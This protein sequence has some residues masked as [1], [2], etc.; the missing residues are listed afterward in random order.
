MKNMTLLS[1][2]LS[3]LSLLGLIFASSACSK[4]SS[5]NISQ[6]ISSE[7]SNWSNAFGIFSN[8]PQMDNKSVVLLQFKNPA[9]LSTMQIDMQGNRVIDQD[10]LAAIEGE[11]AD[12]I[13]NFKNISSDITVMYKYRM[14]LNAMAIVAPNSILDKLTS[15]G[16]VTYV[17]KDGVFAKPKMMEAEVGSSS[18]DLNSAN[19]AKFIGAYAVHKMTIKDRTGKTIPLDGTGMRVGIIDTGIDYTHA[20]LGGAGT[21][22]AFQAIDPSHPSTVFPT[23]KVIGG[24]D[25]VGTNYDSASLNSDKRVPTP[26][27]NPIDELGHGSHVAGTIAGVG[28][29]I[30]TYDG[31]APGAKLYAIKVFGS[32]GSSGDAVVIAG[33]EYAADPTGQADP[34]QSLDAVNLSLG[35]TFGS[36]HVLYQ[37]A[38]RNLTKAGTVVVAAAGNEGA[39]DYVVGA[40]SVSTDALSIAASIDNAPQ[41]WQFPAVKFNYTGGSLVTQ[42][43]AATI[44]TSLNQVGTLSGTLVMAGLGDSDF[45][46]DVKAKLKGQVAL[47]DR[48][49]VSFEDKIRR[50]QD[51]G[52]IGVVVANT[53]D[54]DPY[55]MGGAGTYSLPAVMVSQG[56]GDAVKEKMKSGA[57]TIQF[58]IPDKILKKELI[59][60]VA[61]FSSKG[62]RSFDSAIKPEISA[63]GLN[64]ISISMGSGNK[65]VAMSGTSMST[66]HM[67]GV[68]TV[69]KELHPDLSVAQLKSLVMST[70]ISLKDTKGQEYPVSFQGA[71][72]VRLDKAVL[73][74]AV[75]EP[76]ALSLGEQNLSSKKTVRATIIVKNISKTK[77]TFVPSFRARV[78]GIQMQPASSLVLAPGDSGQMVFNFTLDSST[79]GDPTEELDG[80]LTLKTGGPVD[81]SL[82]VLAVI[83]KIS[84]I[85]AQQLITHASADDAAGASVDLKVKNSG[86]NMGDVMLFNLLGLDTRKSNPKHAYDLDTSCNLQAAGYRIITKEISGQPRKMIQFAAKLFEPETTWNT[87]EISVLI[88]KDGKGVPSQE[89]A[90]IALSGVAGLSSSTAAGANQFSSV[91]FDAVRARDIRKQ[92]ELVSQTKSKISAL[93][94]YSPS[95][96]DENDMQ[97]INHTTI[98]IIEAPIDELTATDDGELS[99]R[100]ATISDNVSVGADD[101]LEQTASQWTR[102]SLQADSQAFSGMPETSTLLPGQS[103]TLALTK[104]FGTQDLLL[105][106]PQNA[107]VFSDLVEDGQGQVM[108]TEF[109]P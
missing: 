20:M 91:L 88:D 8:R 50:A 56:A 93:E 108:K 51:A 79:V 73:A 98:A 21:T 59:D 44:G 25:F 49:G 107:N 39:L 16:S 102:I 85:T 41:N 14:V 74:Q 12:A 84:A 54:G 45:A 57:V 105:L 94:D 66:P 29:G 5:Q 65:G 18:P 4:Q 62:P 36:A 40:P 86:T 92:F 42:T 35:G 13:A 53:D 34:T 64:V 9:L 32:A 96:I 2:F 15:L 23:A 83:K 31:V 80:F 68:M 6:N 90:G 70:A 61:D 89:L 87:C 67:T 33:L 77:V 82:P 97:A 1:R 104:G 63:P 24:M 3:G 81:L 100:V 37:Q 101:F 72:R 99:V 19:S 17:E 7:K 38:I 58:N 30:N 55:A 109:G 10:L 106:Y 27:M 60:T 28:D 95:V 47:F 46:S 43:A 69:L 52:C 71:G 48:G 26:D 103:L 76:A 78:K 11:Q 22:A 75:T